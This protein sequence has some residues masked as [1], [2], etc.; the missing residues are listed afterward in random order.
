MLDQLLLN[1]RVHLRFFARNRLLLAFG[2]V[3]LLLF[4]VTLV[5]MVL[6]QS[7][8]D[9]FNLLRSIT[10]Q[11]SGYALVF[12]ASLGLFAISSHL[13]NRN[14]KMV[15]TKPCLPET[16]LAS[17]FLSALL[18][19]VAIHALLALA[20]ALLSWFWGIPWQWG[21]VF[22]AADGACRAMI[23]MSLLTCL[24]TAFHPV[25]AVLVA[26]FFNE[27]TFYQL[28]FLVAGAGTADGGNARLTA[29]G[30]L[31]DS[32]YMILPMADPFADRT[33]EV[34]Q[35]LRVGVGDWLSLGMA[36]GYSALLSAFL[37]LVTDYLLRRKRL[38]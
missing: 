12:T 14:V 30:V 6:F 24:A 38:I 11:M 22:V 5:P 18:I 21:F 19:A 34:Y 4:G 7:S 16:W 3:M 32:I 10:G 27:G 9:R 31:C 36:I 37:F 17:I 28:K 15:L 29:A 8:S 25:V 20:A 13:R 33:K 2:L 26:L 1:T 35:S 23:Q